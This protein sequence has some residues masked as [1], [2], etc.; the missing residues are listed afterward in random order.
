MSVKS[1][2]IQVRPVQES[3]LMPALW[4][5]FAHEPDSERAI[6][7]RQTVEQ[8]RK[9]PETVSRLFGA[10]RGPSLVGVLWAIN[11]PGGTSI[12][13]LPV[14]IAQS[15]SER[16]KL[17]QSLFERALTLLAKDRIQIVQMLLTSQEYGANLS[18]LDNFA[19]RCETQLNYYNKTVREPNPATVSDI[20]FVPSD[21][22][23]EG[24]LHEL[25]A[26]TFVE[27][28]DCPFLRDRRKVEDALDGYESSGD[29][30]RK[31]WEVIVLNGT[32]CGVL[33]PSL[34]KK[35]EQLEVVYVGLANQYRYQRLGDQV[36]HRIGTIAHQL[37]CRQIVV[38]VDEQNE[39]AKRWYVRHNFSMWE[40]RQLLIHWMSSGT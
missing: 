5:A 26:A 2:A 29:T 33:L 27:S 13:A 1:P 16:A 39:P 22:I 36:M 37:H 3:E 12:L 31:Y 20:S 4:L 8:S 34:H 28:H 23:S 14:V 17:E 18:L 10:F 9:Q 30:G 25:I 6:S 11:S 19:F 21:T 15:R 38:A 35:T 7:V 32:P 24:E 40:Q